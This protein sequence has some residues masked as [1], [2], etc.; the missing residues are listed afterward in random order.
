VLD[1]AVEHVLEGDG[2]SCG[3]RVAGGVGLQ[4]TVEVVQVVH[5]NEAYSQISGGVMCV[6]WWE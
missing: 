3:A 1:V 6:C 5:G 4:A 2:C